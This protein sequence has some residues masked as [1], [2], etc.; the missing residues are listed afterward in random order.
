M[1]AMA[2]THICWSCCTRKTLKIW[3]NRL[4]HFG[5][6]IDIIL[7]ANF[8]CIRRDPMMQKG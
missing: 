3:G 7:E 8:I 4:F 6:K 2:R 1:I 5:V